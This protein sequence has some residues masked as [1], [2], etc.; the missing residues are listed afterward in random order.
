MLAISLHKTDV[1][2]GKYILPVYPFIDMWFLLGAE[3]ISSFF[4]SQI[5]LEFII[6]L[7]FLFSF[8]T[9]YKHVTQVTD[10]IKALGFATWISYYY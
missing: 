5:P 4:F 2:S 9:K 10:S 1:F 3:N 6:C 8:I 7:Q